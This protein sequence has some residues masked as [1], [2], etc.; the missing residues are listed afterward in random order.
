MNV[1]ISTW[2]NLERE[3]YRD[4]NEYIADKVEGAMFRSI[5][6]YLR[7]KL[8][9]S[10]TASI[11]MP[12]GTYY[13]E[14]KTQDDGTTVVDVTWEPSKGFKRLLDEDIDAARFDR[15]YQDE[16]EP[17]FVTLFTD[18]L[19]FGKFDPTE[20]DKTDEKKFGLMLEDSEVSY[21]LNSYVLALYNVAKEKERDGKTYR[22]ELHESC[23]HGAFDFVYKDDK[24]DVKFIADKV[25]KQ[26]LKDDAVANSVNSGDFSATTDVVKTF[27]PVA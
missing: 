16:F 4:F 7:R 6:E 3:N 13:A 27:K 1:T 21:F 24:I 15:G 10:S 2:V 9:N 8:K 26:H 19:A 23:P 22:L 20:D 14:M 18:Y 17:E 25:F 5:H 11:T 12:Y